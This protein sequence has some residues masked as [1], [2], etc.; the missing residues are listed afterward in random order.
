MRSKQNVLF[1]K[2]TPKDL[3]ALCALRAQLAHDPMDKQATE[4]APYSPEPD[5]A[6]INKCLHARNKVILIAERQGQV[7][8]HS[9][10]LIETASP[11]L[12][13]YY[14][15]NKK[16]LLVHLYVD[17]NNRRQGIGSALMEYTFKY[18]RQLNVDFVD[19]ECAPQ[20]DKAL[21]L[22]NKMGFQD[23]WIKKRLMLS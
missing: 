3:E 2:A 7:L 18:L 16:A 17:E 1:R 11:K 15:Y 10:V 13:I 4:Y 21:T 5:R 20:N 19:L 12:R 14:T 9:I 8:A 23:I 22:Y 6:W